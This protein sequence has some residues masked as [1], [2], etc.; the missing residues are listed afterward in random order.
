[1]T[2]SSLAE[3]KRWRKSVGK[4]PFNRR[5]IGG[6]VN[7]KLLMGIGMG[8]SKKSNIANLGGSDNHLDSK[9]SVKKKSTLN[10]KKSAVPS[11][12]VGLKDDPV[13]RYHQMVQNGGSSTGSNQRVS[14]VS[15]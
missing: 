13:K 10:P 3:S 14:N 5:L 8:I 9:S 6:A 12:M 2:S 4:Y 15:K 7:S 1:M 11:A